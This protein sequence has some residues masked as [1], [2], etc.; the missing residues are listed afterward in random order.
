MKSFPETE[1]NLGFPFC[2]ISN[3]T[4]FQVLGLDNMYINIKQPFYWLNPP[5][6]ITKRLSERLQ[7]LQC[8][9]PNEIYNYCNKGH[10]YS[11]NRLMNY[12]TR[13]LALNISC[14]AG[15]AW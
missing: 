9:G 10:T 5:T 14:S 13:I 1:E 12:S 6:K 4:K 2:L 15:S 7:T 3:S 11:K 8:S